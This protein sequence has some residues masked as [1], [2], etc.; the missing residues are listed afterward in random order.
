[1]TLFEALTGRPPF[2][3]PDLV[4]QHLGEAPPPPSSLRAGLAPSHDQVL[5]RAL[6]KSPDDRFVSAAEMG[7]ALAGWPAG[8]E[9]AAAGS[10]AARPSGAVEPA[11]P[12]VAVESREIGPTGAGRLLLHR[13]GRTGRFVLA[14]ERATPLDDDALAEVRQLAAAGGPAVQRVLRLA[15]DRRTIWYEVIAGEHLPLERTTPEERARL[16]PVLASWPAG[17]LP[18][19]FARTPAGPVLLVAPEV[20]A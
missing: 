3:G 10:G 9:A 14:E 2:L 19:S 1:V 17:T 5:L 15:D 20:S 4:A 18:T 11:D 7:E 8:G 6:A 12:G 16:A 13:D